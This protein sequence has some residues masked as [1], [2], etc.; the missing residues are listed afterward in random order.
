MYIIMICAGVDPGF[1]VGGSANPPGRGCQPMILPNFPKNCMKLRKFW[2]MG[3][4]AGGAPLR[5]DTDMQ[6]LNYV[7]I[8]QFVTLPDLL[9]V[10]LE[11]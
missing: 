2:T 1:S 3:G 8:M 11:G 9:T 5:S 6:K 7:I 10:V 4:R